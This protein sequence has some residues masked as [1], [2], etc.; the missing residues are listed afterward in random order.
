MDN[1]F[2]PPKSATYAPPQLPA[3]QIPENVEKAI[4]Q[5]AIAGFV[6]A[7]LGVLLLIFVL[8]TGVSDFLPVPI[9]LYNLFDFAIYV[10]CSIFILRRSRFAAV[11]LLLIYAFN[12]IATHT[13]AGEFKPVSLVLPVIVA[14]FMARGIW[15]TFAYH[16]IRK[17]ADPSY[18]AAPK[19]ATW[20]LLPAG[21]VL[22][23]CL[24]CIGG[25]TFFGPPTEVT[26]GA[27][28]NPKFVR[29]LKDNGI[30]EEDETVEWFYSAGMFSVVEEGNILTNWRAISY[31]NY[32]GEEF[33]ASASYEEITDLSL[34]R[35]DFFNDSIITV[36]CDD[37]STFELWITVSMGGD[38][39]FLEELK[40][41]TD[42]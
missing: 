36:S 13:M 41:R 12:M 35:G 7:G 40:K 14:I 18:K 26:A 27:D 30:I 22:I 15:G 39:R 11:F 2:E 20:V 31:D 3:P 19:W 33:H 1:P 38:D 23:V 28:L 25:V 6:I 21:V 37:G 24:G 16:K 4:R 8:T 9:D 17:Q 34:K 32:D 5:A 29:E 42:N 10:V